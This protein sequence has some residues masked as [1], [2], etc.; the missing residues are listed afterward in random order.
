MN[1]VIEGNMFSSEM[2]K[3]ANDIVAVTGL[4][5]LAVA[6][7][8][9]KHKDYSL[10]H[11][12]IGILMLIGGIS[13]Q[14]YGRALAFSAMDLGGPASGDF[15][16]AKTFTIVSAYLIAF[17]ILEFF[18]EIN[19]EKWFKKNRS[20]RRMI[21]TACFVAFLIFSAVFAKNPRIHVLYGAFL[22]Q[23]LLL[24]LISRNT[25]IARYGRIRYLT[26]LCFPVC[27]LI[28]DIIFPLFRVHGLGL[29]FMYFLM[30]LAYNQRI[31]QELISKE[32]ELSQ[33]KV[34]L[35][36]EQI[37]PHF[38]FNSLQSI[39]GISDKEPNEVRP[40]IELF[41]GYLRDNLE[42]LTNDELIHFSKELEHTKVYIELAKMSGSRD[43]D[44]EYR[45]ETVD[46]MV[47]P[48]ILQ[49]L[50]ENAVLYG[51]GSNAE[52]SK[53]IIE[54]A[55]HPDRVEIRVMNEVGE[56]GDPVRRQNTHKSVGLK[57][58][59]TRVETQCGGT[60]TLKTAD[61]ITTATIVLPKA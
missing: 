4:F 38:I 2:I 55:E 48:L 54:T 53:I 18:W 41:S 7:T 58:V 22:I 61:G 1:G 43:F 19:G 12:L 29:F 11:A 3:S 26:M 16:E 13:F 9:Q 14:T 59:R 27:A 33:N 42:S 51:T 35:L 45:L 60:L 36:M 20:T 34:Q 52:Q 56:T 15:R 39:A 31:E 30:Y 25:G 49:P 28:I 24:S 44:V 47:P 46:F 6:I 21:C 23:I 8:R 32:L 50:V 37:S 10:G 5:I 57:N 40:A 17:S